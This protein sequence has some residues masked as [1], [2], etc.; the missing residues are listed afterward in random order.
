MPKGRRRLSS[1]GNAFC[2]I[3]PLCHHANPQDALWRHQ[4]EAWLAA[5]RSPSNGLA[6]LSAPAL[7]DALRLP[8]CRSL[9]QALHRLGSWPAGLWYAT[10]ES[11]GLHGRLLVV[12]LH[13]PSGSLRMQ[14]PQH[15]TLIDHVPGAEAWHLRPGWRV[16]FDAADGGATRVRLTMQPAD[17][18]LSIG[19]ACCCLPN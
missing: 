10:N 8:S 1:A 6:A 16:L 17:D 18:V 2:L 4:C 13:P 9:Y 12:Q 7:R 19:K 11:A 14:P 3:A 15:R 5:A